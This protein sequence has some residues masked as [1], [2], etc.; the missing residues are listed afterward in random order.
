MTHDGRSFKW[1]E[2]WYGVSFDKQGLLLPGRSCLPVLA[3][4]GPWSNK[5]SMA[6]P[7]RMLHHLSLTIPQ[8]EIDS[9]VPESVVVLES[10]WM[11][12]PKTTMSRVDAPHAV[13]THLAV[14]DVCTAAWRKGDGDRG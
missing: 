1:A 6:Y 8:G 5:Q 13:A 2:S 4:G 14:G 10:C 3:A 7:I 11:V 12:A 9:K